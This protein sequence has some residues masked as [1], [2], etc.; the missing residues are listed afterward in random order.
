MPPA[1]AAMATVAARPAAVDAPPHRA[2]VL[3]V[4]TRHRGGGAR[5]AAVAASRTDRSH[6]VAVRVAGRLFIGHMSPEQW[7]IIG[8]VALER[9]RYSAPPSHVLA[10]SS[11]SISVTIKPCRSVWC[12]VPHVVER[13]ILWETMCIA[14][15]SHPQLS[16]T[17]HLGSCTWHATRVA[18]NTDVEDATAPASRPLPLAPYCRARQRP[19]CKPLVPAAHKACSSRPCP[20]LDGDS[21]TAGAPPPQRRRP[22]TSPTWVMT[23]SGW[24]PPP[25]GGRG[26]PWASWARA[27]ARGRRRWIRSRSCS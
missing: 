12:L 6:R 3:P 10:Q 24:S 18:G 4:G 5:S 22:W 19:S 7:T 15:V 25:R 8:S 16:S 20:L 14:L 11:E 26:P 1:A 21:M 23:A 2:T 13:E 9:R 17:A 27:A